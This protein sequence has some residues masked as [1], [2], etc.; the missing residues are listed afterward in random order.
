MNRYRAAV[1]GLGSIGMGYDYDD[2]DGTRVLTH[3]A[4]FAAHPGFILVGGVDSSPAARE[5]FTHKYRQPA[6]A[7]VDELFAA[8]RPEVTAV[9]VPTPL[10]HA[11]F[12]QVM[13]HTPR[14]VICEKPLGATLAEAQAMAGLAARQGTL[15]AVNYMRRFE[16][17]VLAL[18]AA[19]ASGEYGDIHKGTVWYSK[20]L[21]NNCSHFIDLLAF[22][23]G[24]VTD[25]A[26]LAPGRELGDD[27]EPD[28]RLSFG[29][30][31]VYFL[32]GR[33]ECFAVKEIELMATRAAI[34]YERGGAAITVRPTVPHPTFAG[35][36]VLAAAGYTV[37]T[38]FDRYQHHVAAA[39]YG[40]L[41]GGEPPRSTG[42][43]A[44]ATL[45]VVDKILTLHREAKQ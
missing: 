35:Y 38:D 12:G 17:G 3:A 2:A 42:A 6:F 29:A 25:I 13:A 9:A 5:R 27:P 1:I 32:A 41:E 18:R 21:R 24:P 4:A 31:D 7:T 28:F 33:E 39:L 14:A 40:A 22:L 10:H 45:A 16:P 30:A 20:G 43:T 8:C 36:T 23:L 34:R 19:I 15:L 11:V 44:L 26:L 37:P